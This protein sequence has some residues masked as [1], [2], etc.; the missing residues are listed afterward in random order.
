MAFDRTT[1]KLLNHPFKPWVTGTYYSLG[2]LVFYNNNLYEALED[3]TAGS[4]FAEDTAKWVSRMTGEAT[5][6]A[7]HVTYD[8]TSSR[9]VADDVQSAIDELSVAS[10]IFRQKPTSAAVVEGDV[11]VLTNGEWVPLDGTV[12]V[13]DNISWGIAVN[14]DTDTH[15]ADVLYGGK[16]I[17]ALV[18]TVGDW[19]CDASGKL[20]Q[21]VTQFFVGYSFSIGFLYL[22]LVNTVV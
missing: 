16:L 11:V 15:I 2:E 19:Y 7:D 12:E 1:L 8:N 9:L 14:V 6:N 21:T 13:S 22:D 17:S 3:H 4:T 10:P 5:S 18:T 20:T